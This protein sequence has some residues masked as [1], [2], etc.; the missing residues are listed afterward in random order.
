MGE[1]EE[2]G[3]MIGEEF[4]VCGLLFVKPSA[5]CVFALSELDESVDGV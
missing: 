1:S 4:D 2:F 3:N 5:C